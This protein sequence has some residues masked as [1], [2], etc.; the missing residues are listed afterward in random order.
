MRVE[1]DRA[2]TR[3]RLSRLSSYMAR[4]V[5][6]SGHFRCKSADVRRASALAQGRS[7]FEGQLSYV[8]NHYD[9]TIDRCAFRIVIS[10]QEYGQARKLVTLPERYEMIHDRSGLAGWASR[11]PHMRGTT[12]ALRVLLGR[13]PGSDTEGEWLET[14][15]RARFHI[16]DAF[17][18]V[19]VLLCSAVVPG[20]MN[21]RSS[22]E[23]RAN[24]L[25]HY[26]ATLAFLEPNVLVL[27][28]MGVREWIDP[29]IAEVERLTANVCR[30]VIA[31][32]ALLL[33]EFSHPSAHEP[34]AWGDL[35]RQYLGNVVVPSLRLAREAL[36][37]H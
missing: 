21:G 10:G 4:E 17:A 18:L 25:C 13:A 16:F 26:A 35:S 36:L 31:G 34:L 8:G 32:Q 3:G 14:D 19:N 6:T 22:R 33:C 37:R 30:A 28:S 29:L 12:S 7:F 5:C 1:V 2:L 20:T 24:C 27:Q 23:M 9:L 15:A 11:N